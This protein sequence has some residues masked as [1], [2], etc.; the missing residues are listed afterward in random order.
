LHKYNTM[1]KIFLLFAILFITSTISAQNGSTNVVDT[2]AYVRIPEIPPFNLT[3]VNDS[4]AFDKSH[5]AKKKKT[6]IFIF[7]PSCDH[8]IKATDEMIANIDKFKKVNIVMATVTSY[9][10]TK[11][12][13]DEHNFKNYPNIKVGVDTKYF[14]GTFYGIKMYPAIFLYNKKGKFEHRFQSSDSMETIA[15]ML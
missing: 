6:L 5:L 8:C 15:K 13:Y 2:P 14:L 1:N 4:T 3:L 7:S 10:F 11:K 9:F 12:F